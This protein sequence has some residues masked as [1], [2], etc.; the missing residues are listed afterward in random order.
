MPILIEPY[1]PDRV[2]AALEF[3][4]RLRAA[5]VALFGLQGSPVPEWLP[6]APDE[7]LY[8][9]FFLANDGDAVRG[10]YTLKHQQFSLNGV[11]DTVGFVYSPIS[12]GIIDQRFGSLGMRLMGHA[13]KRQPL[14]FC[15]GMGGYDNPLP[16]LLTAMGWTLVSV[17]FFLR[18]VRPNQFLRQLSYLDRF[19]GGRL[20]ARVLAGTGMGWAAAKLVNGLRAHAAANADTLEWKLVPE[21]PPDVDRVWTA[22][23][24]S[25]AFAAVR[26][27]VSL[28]RIY[29]P[30]YK[31]QLRILVLKEDRLIGWAVA[32]DTQMRGHKFFGDARL[33]SVIDCLALSGC[34]HDVVSAATAMLEARGV[35][36]IV[37]NQAHNAWASAFRRGGWLQ[38]PSNYIFAASPKLAARFGSMTDAFDRFHITRGDGE[39][40]SNL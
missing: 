15:L 9:E 1:A 21:F 4:K 30:R 13:Q 26:D 8:E 7:A 10:G 11:L 20:C 38:G 12:E 17:P 39:G 2:D 19:P 31:N 27:H 24:D 22:A 5:G 16:K 40:P 33:G 29:P 3:N 37:T 25:Y 32:L 36:V 23:S 14:L 28:N 6:P 35:D 34:E 18:I